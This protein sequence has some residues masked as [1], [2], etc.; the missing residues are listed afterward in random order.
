[1]LTFLGKKFDGRFKGEQINSMK[2]RWPGA[3]IKH[4]MKTNWI[5]MYNKCGCVLRVETV[6]NDPYSFRILRYGKRKGE[7]VYAWFP[8]GKGVANLYR[9]AEIS[10]AANGSYLDAISVESDP[11]PAR[12]SLR[13]LT[14][15][16]TYK[17]R[18]FKAFRKIIFYC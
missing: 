8:M 4:W 3:R 5:K 18:L 11:R 14:V 9:Y 10:L 2:T 1:M 6:V 16:V 17:N 15:P 12:E 7:L 13:K